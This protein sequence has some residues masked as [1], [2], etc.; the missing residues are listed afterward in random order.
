MKIHEL[1]D[2]P[3]ADEIMKLDKEDLDSMPYNVLKWEC[4]FNG[5]KCG[6]TVRDYGLH[7][8]YFLNRNSKA[9]ERNPKKYWFDLRVIHWFCGKH[10][11]YYQRLGAEYVFNKFAVD[12]GFPVEVVKKVNYINE[13]I[14]F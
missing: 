14:K 8:F 9:A 13:Q 2:E 11:K 3:T 5:C 1:S 7:P 10:W 12:K 6:T 4:C